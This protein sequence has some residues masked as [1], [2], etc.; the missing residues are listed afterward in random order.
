MQQF[1]G[2]SKRPCSTFIPVYR[3]IRRAAGTYFLSLLPAVGH[4]LISPFFACEVKSTSPRQERF[5]LIYM[6]LPSFLLVII[7]L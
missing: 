4:F 1:A 7:P 3:N 6:Y 2:F 5:L